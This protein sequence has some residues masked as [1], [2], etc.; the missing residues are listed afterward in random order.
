MKNL[1]FLNLGTPEIIIL[2]FIG[3]L[4]FA[5]MLFCLIDIIRSDFNVSTNKLVWVLVVI[6]APVIGSLLYLL[7]GR[8]QKQI[9]SQVN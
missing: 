1:L 8:K 2:L 6:F 7:F 5:L 3:V 4:P 9:R